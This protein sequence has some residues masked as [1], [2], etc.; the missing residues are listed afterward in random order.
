MGWVGG[1]WE[2]RLPLGSHGRT[3]YRGG[4][5]GRGLVLGH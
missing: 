3:G 5:W 2:G 1:R 4:G